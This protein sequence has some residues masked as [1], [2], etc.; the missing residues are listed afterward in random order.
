MLGF[1][2]EVIAYWLVPLII[3]CAILLGGI[4][5]A[6]KFDVFKNLS[7]EAQKY[8]SYYNASGEIVVS[9]L[10]DSYISSIGGREALESIRSIRYQGRL[11]ESGAETNFQILIKQ[12]DKGMI[13]VSPGENGSQKLLLNGNMA[14]QVVRTG[15]GGRRIVPIG[16]TDAA[17][18]AWSLRVHNT[19]RRLS[20]DGGQALDGLSA[21]EIEFQG[22][23]C[24]ELT[25]LMPDGSEFV[26]VLDKENLYLLKMVESAPGVDGM[27]RVETVYGDHRQTS[28]LVFAYETKIRK[29]GNTYNETYLDSIEINPGLVSSLFAIPEQIKK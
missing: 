20:L 29:S 6:F 15:D 10:M 19:F 21:R 2:F 5:A 28:G 22:K 24:I 13:I 12:P 17:S 1:R 25:K 7:G 11:L 18:L 16:D 27:E 3:F 9:E 4:Y 26:A 8:A 14:W 23:P